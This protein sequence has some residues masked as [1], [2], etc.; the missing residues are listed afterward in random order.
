MKK[1]LI[2]SFATCAMI[3]ASCGNKTKDAIALA[4]SDSLMMDTSIVAA[5]AVDGL[6]EDLKTTITNLTT[7]L[8]EDLKA[9]NTQNIIVGL[10]NLETIYRNLAAASK[11]ED[12][13]VYGTAIK[14]FINSNS[15]A[16]KAS[17]SENATI[18]SLV[19]SIQNLP[20]TA[21]TTAEQAKAAVANDIA[22]LA[23]PAIAKGETA[24]ATAEA[25]AKLI[26]NAPA[27]AK[28]AAEDAA[29][30]VANNTKAAVDNQVDAAKASANKAVSNAQDKT[31][32]AIT[33]T[34][35]KANKKVNEAADKANK[36]INDAAKEAIKGIGL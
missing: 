28:K 6:S 32:K 27:T 5:V 35:E 30:N 31:N 14:N 23:S 21:E 4:D 9:N 29:A 3:M 13:K 24:V 15:E 20:T 18:G 1:L 12:A 19:Q 25:A 16:L 17:V 11:L 33:D 2:L 7:K 22:T 10:A 36:K 8:T 26:E 34:K